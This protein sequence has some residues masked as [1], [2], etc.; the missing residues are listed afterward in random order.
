MS[1]RALMSRLRYQI[2]IAMAMVGLCALAAPALAHDGQHPVT[3]AQDQ[4]VNHDYFAA[5]SMVEIDG[6]VNGDIYAAGGQVTINGTVNGD[7]LAAGG[8][9]TVDGTVNGNV[10]TT[11]GSVI[12]DGRVTK[13]VSIAGGNIEVGHSA[14]IAGNLAVAAGTLTDS[15]TVNGDANAATGNLTVGS[16][17]H[18]G[19]TLTYWSNQPGSIA[20]GAVVGTVTH[21]VPPAHHNENRN[22]F[23]GA[24]L[25]ALYWF[26]VTYIVAV[27]AMLWLPRHSLAITEALQKRPWSSFGWGI[28]I[29]I[30]TPLAGLV[31][32]ITVIGI[33]FG[34]ALWALY[35][36][37]LF[38]APVWVI[39]ATRE[40]LA[41]QFKRENTFV[42]LLLAAFIYALIGLIPVVGTIFI[43]VTSLMGLGASVT[44]GFGAYRHLRQKN[45]L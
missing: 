40:L 37:A 42:V 43:I 36:V 11:G 13:N 41:G 38:L 8:T 28:L 27:L 15:G 12:I 7:V 6:T 17:A 4:T 21:R 23:G 24:L 18:I 34:L 3:L 22:R 33:P 30:L 35:A 44:S 5:G 9:V 39:M 1:G 32:L 16:V 19:G 10:R 2:G 31:L 20:Q 25:M 26:V 45:E 29:A 14:T